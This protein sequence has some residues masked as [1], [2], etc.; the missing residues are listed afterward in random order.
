MNGITGFISVNDILFPLSFISSSLL[1]FTIILFYVHWFIIACMYV[2]VRV[3]D[4]GVTDTC[5]CHVS[6]GN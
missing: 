2:C 4:L 6:A 5:D 3:P 1:F